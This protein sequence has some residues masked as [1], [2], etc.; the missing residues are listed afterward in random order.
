VTGG[1]AGVEED[2]WGRDVEDDDAE[3]EAEPREGS[4]VQAKLTCGDR[5][6]GE[7]GPAG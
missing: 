2:V 3:C 6:P 4:E 7:G 5:R 1:R